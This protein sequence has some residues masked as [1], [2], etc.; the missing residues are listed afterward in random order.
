MIY[1]GPNWTICVS[2]RFGLLQMVSKLDTERCGS[3]NVGLQRGR[4]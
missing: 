1:N 4:L 2:G 3:E